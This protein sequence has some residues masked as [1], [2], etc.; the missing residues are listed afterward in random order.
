VRTQNAKR[1]RDRETDGDGGGVERSPQLGVFVDQPPVLR[2][3]LV[4]L[5]LYPRHT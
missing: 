1:E 3:V 5:I 2:H 4:L